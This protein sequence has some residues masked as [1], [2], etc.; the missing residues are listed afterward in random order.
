MGPMARRR[1][2]GS[3]SLGDKAELLQSPRA[4]VEADLLG[5][6]AV[7]DRGWLGRGLAR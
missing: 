6:E 5:D 1:V 2:C 7:L 4:V 3:A